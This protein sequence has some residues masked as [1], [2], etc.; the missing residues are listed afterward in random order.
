MVRE[1]LLG[2]QAQGSVRLSD[3][4]RALDEAVAMK[5]VIEWL[6]DA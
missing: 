3:I 5:K 4:T 1:V 2:I 6:G